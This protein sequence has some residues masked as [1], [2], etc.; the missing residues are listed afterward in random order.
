METEQETAVPA[1]LRFADAAL[2][3]ALD[4]HDTGLEQARADLAHEDDAFGALCAN[5]D[6]HGVVREVLALL[7]ACETDLS[8]TARLATLTGSGRPG[9]LTLGAAAR[10]L[11]GTGA[12][13]AATGPGSPLRRTA[14]VDLAGTGP[15]STTEI[16]LAPGVVWALAGDPSPDP[17]LP[18]GVWMM[19]APPGPVAHDDRLVLVSGPDPVRRRALATRRRAAAAYLV[20]PTPAGE[21]GWAALVR[22]ATLTGS[23]VLV[24]LGDD[25]PAAGRR[26][27]D[28]ATHLPWVVSTRDEIPLAE[29]PTRERI[30]LRAGDDVVSDEEWREVFGDD[31]PRTHR[32]S[33]HQLEQVGSALPAVGD[34]DLAV[35][36]L[37]AGPLAR[38][39]R[40]VRPSK[41][42]DDLV[43]GEPQLDQLRTI[44]ARFRH[45]G[46]VYD[47]WGVTSAS[48]RGI[49]SLFTGPSGTGKS[50]AAEVVAH[51]LGLDLYKVDLSSV[52]SKYI[53]ETEQ[54][55]EKL[56]AA[57]SAGSAVLFFDEADSLFGKRSDVKDGRD[58]YANLEVSYLLQRLESYDGVVVLA[59]N[60]PKNIDDAFL[61]R[62]H[63]VVS[64]T[65]PAVEERRAIWAHHLADGDLPVDPD[66]DLDRLSGRFEVAGGIIRNVVVSAAFRAADEGGSIRMAH[67]L[68]ALS[69]EYKKLGRLL[70]P[71][72]FEVAG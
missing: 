52:V 37:L 8:R 17:D 21:E 40:R 12:V 3:L 28:R 4:G 36:R 47:D 55:L 26:W 19:E 18:L 6:A 20:S 72:D 32:L 9:R 24:E 61:R 43:L 13:V 30:E 1:F 63:E 44:A 22:E 27:I 59:T 35:R 23:G 48:G 7:L 53:G 29:L 46:T 66:V 2:D 14:L 39:A 58:R 49:V 42:W 64:F 33:A 41:T 60:L 11:G 68:H 16:V 71:E 10:L 56:F 51:T 25:L 57:A 45:A 69:G 67:L 38:L 15:W 5:V 54:N 62:I 70:N 65:L 31:V 34:L 50:L